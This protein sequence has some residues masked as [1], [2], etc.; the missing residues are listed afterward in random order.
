MEDRL[1]T[2]LSDVDFPSDRAGLLRQAAARGADY[3]LLGHLAALPEG[4]Y[5]SPD[6]VI[7]KVPRAPR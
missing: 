6:A 1:R 3:D 4:S 2:L 5:S 7:A